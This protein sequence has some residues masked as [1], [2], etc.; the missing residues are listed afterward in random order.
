MDTWLRGLGKTWSN[1]AI[2]SAVDHPSLAKDAVN[3]PLYNICHRNHQ[4]QA[5]EAT[6]SPQAFSFL[7]IDG[8][9]RHTTSSTMGSTSDSEVIY[10][11]VCLL[12]PTHATA[13]S[14]KAKTLT[15]RDLPRT[16]RARTRCSPP[17][18]RSQKST[19]SSGTSKPNASGKATKPGTWCK[20]F[21]CECTTP[22]QHG[23][24]R[25]TTSVRR[26]HGEEEPAQLPLRRARRLLI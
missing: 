5:F 2:S 18:T 10:Y 8:L 3:T 19:T 7:G 16:S 13:Q 6:L 9:E 25:S 24:S 20:S 26:T 17:S 14:H 15:A 22:D 21:T 11:R 23:I 12:P 1:A 4:N